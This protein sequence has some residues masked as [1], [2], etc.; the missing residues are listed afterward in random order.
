MFTT[1]AIRFSMTYI[2]VGQTV[3]SL[4]YKSAHST[5]GRHPHMNNAPK[6]VAYLSYTQTNNAK[7][8]TDVTQHG[9]TQLSQDVQL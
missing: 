2:Q 7:K 3:I 5:E 1:D 4:Q 8:K 6:H 9:Y